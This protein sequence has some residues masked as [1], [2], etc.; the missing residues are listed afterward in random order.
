MIEENKDE[1][2]VV[3]G[4][5]QSSSGDKL[6]EKEPVDSFVEIETGGEGAVQ[7]CMDNPIGVNNVAIG[8][9]AGLS[10]PY[11]ACPFLSIGNFVS[12][13]PKED[14]LS[15]QQE[16]E[17]IGMARTFKPI[18]EIDD[19]SKGLLATVMSNVRSFFTGW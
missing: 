19:S 12:P 9:H 16:L 1:Q 10:A 17:S 13:D 4:E 7:Y 5:N 3:Q 18:K 15:I 14:T 2:D 11:V 6:E 8:F